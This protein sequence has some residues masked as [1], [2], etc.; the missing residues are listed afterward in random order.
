MR[1]A[2]LALLTLALAIMPA[3][4]TL[5]VFGNADMDNTIDELD[6]EYVRGVI[7]G[8]NDPTNLADANQDGEIDEN[9][10]VQIGMII[11]GKETELSILD[12]NGEPVTVHKPV[13]RI[14]VEYLDNAELVS[15]LNASDKVVG[16]DYAVAKSEFQFPDLSK[17]A[18]IG[19]MNEPDY[20]AVLS[21]NPDLLLTFSPLNTQIKADNLPGVDVVFLGLYYPDLSDPKSSKF[22]DG[23]RKLGYI[24]DEE[25]RAEEYLTWR[26]GW[27]EEISSQGKSVSVED[28]PKVLICAYPYAHLDTGTFRTY[29][30]I[31]T[32]TQMAMLT[33]SRVMAEDLP[34]FLGSSYRIDVDPEWV[35]EQDPDIILLHLVAHTYSGMSLDPANG[36]DADDPTDIEAAREAFTS[37][38][39][40]AGMTAVKNGDVYLECGSFRNDASGGLIGAAYMAKLFM[41]ETFANLDPEAIHQEY[42]SRFL[43]LDYDLN[44]HGI[45]LYPPIV[46]GE[47]QLAGVPDQ[48]YESVAA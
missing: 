39:E 7:D 10:I 29:S 38:L 37:R 33:G 28:R 11:E 40:L 42:L 41:P 36:Y 27:I 13:E 48:Y 32:L 14:V 1:E 8:T 12:G 43:G 23:V 4:A 26:L 24:L 44:E 17:R 15:I 25:E 16:I 30:L 6:V 34:E 19:Q 5:G 18:N 20:E 45:F 35:I 3:F 22:T 9:D 2:I 31:D 47:G 21:T 46:K